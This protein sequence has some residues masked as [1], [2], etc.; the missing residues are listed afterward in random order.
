VRNLS[1]VWRMDCGARS[2]ARD[3]NDEKMPL[4][5]TCTVPECSKE[6]SFVPEETQ[7]FELPVSLFERRHFY[8][9]ELLPSA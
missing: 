3:T 9:S 2:N 4:K 5:T 8:R 1:G 7:V 6:F